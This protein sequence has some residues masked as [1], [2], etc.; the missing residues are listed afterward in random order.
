[1]K[2]CRRC[3]KPATLHITEIREGQAHAIHL[4]ESCAREYLES[5]QKHPSGVPGEF[6][7]VDSPPV[8]IA[9]ESNIICPN[10]G[11]T[12]SEFRESGRFGCPA[13]YNVFS[14]ELMPLLENIHEE[15]THVGK[16]PKSR[17]VASEDQSR[18]IQLRSQQQEAIEREDYE[19]AARLRDEIS[20]LEGQLQKKPKSRGRKKSTPPPDAE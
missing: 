14:S 20:A 13:D 15:T 10:C 17:Q 7:D 12:Y 6:G 8:D 18:M 2:K 19:T 3:S 16:R 1:M 4:C 11:I 9:A 5:T